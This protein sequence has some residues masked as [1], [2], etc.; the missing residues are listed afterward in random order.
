[1]VRKKRGASS[2]RERDAVTESFGSG[3][4]H[5]HSIGLGA[6]Y[7][8]RQCPRISQETDGGKLAGSLAAPPPGSEGKA[9]QAAGRHSLAGYPGH[10]ARHTKTV[11]SLFPQ[12]YMEY[13]A[14]FTARQHLLRDTETLSVSL[15][16]FIPNI[17]HT[18]QR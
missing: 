6:I 11:L 15:T 8:L 12:Y 13:S 18:R 1:M 5:G 10:V 3:H 4:Q 2:L 17:L 9:K 7:S 16:P 14:L